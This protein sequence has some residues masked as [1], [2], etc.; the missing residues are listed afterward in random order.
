MQ[1]LILP[2]LNHT[3]YPNSVAGFSRLCTRENSPLLTSQS[4]NYLE[5]KK[6][7]LTHVVRMASFAATSTKSVIP[8]PVAMDNVAGPRRCPRRRAR[9]HQPQ[10]MLPPL[11]PRLRHTQSYR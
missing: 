9:Q 3:H 8:T 4:I 2:L 10:L 11:Q 6:L 5:D 1:P 7:V